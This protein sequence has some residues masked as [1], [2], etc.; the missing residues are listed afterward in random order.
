MRLYYGVW[1]GV[2]YDNRETEE[3]LEPEG[4]DIKNLLQF[5]N[6]NPVMTF[7]S[8]R[9]FLV[10]HPHA[11]LLLAL[12]NYYK[13]V[14]ED[15]CGKCTPCR[16]GSIIISEMLEKAASGEEID[17]D[18]LI[19]VARM[20][21]NTSFCGVGQ[22]CPVALIEAIKTFP[23]DLKKAPNPN[24][25]F[26][27]YEVMTAPCIEACPAHVNVP[28]YIDY[29]K[30]GRTDLATG[31][32]LRHY[33]LVGS[34]GRVCVRL[35]E[36][37][38][39]RQ[40]LEGP[41]DI[42]NLKRFAADSLNYTVEEMFEGAAAQPNEFSPRI[43]V[44][45]AGPAGL[46]CAYHLLLKGYK[47]EVY[48]AQRKAGG[49]ALIGI[50]QYRLPKGILLEEAKV[51]EK[52]G[53]KFHYG[54]RLG[55]DFTID[56]LFSEGFN[57]V[58]IGVG[59]SKG[60]LLGF[61]EDAQN[62]EGYSNGLNFLLKVERGVV[63]GE[64]PTFSG[65]F[66]VVGGG[67]VAMDCSRSAVRM[68]DGK[69]HV[70]YRRTEKQAPAD[71][72]EI[73][74]AKEEGIEFHFLT[75]QKRLV[76]EDGKVVGLECVKLKEGESEPNGRSKLIEIPGT[77]FIIP[78]SNVISAIGQRIDQSIF[79]DKDEIQFDKRGNISVTES[80]ATSRPG[81]FAGGD[82]ATGPTTLIGGMAQGQTAAESI[83]EYLTRGSVGFE[84]R[85]RMTQMIKKCALLT[86]TENCLPSMHRERVQMWE[87]NPAIRRKNFE[88]VELGL[89]AEQAKKE[90]ER[91]MRCY[92]LFSVVTQLPIP[93]SDHWAQK[94]GE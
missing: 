67:N 6:G 75:A 16:S 59:C 18:A 9:G 43:A 5:N 66:V 71:P 88:E 35:C 23:N 39:R 27:H 74:A 49:M 42:K 33:P 86:D 83:H 32:V 79:E 8:H 70:I 55:K 46:T 7:V 11:N 56:D 37:A 73:H 26:G 58:F 61:P 24:N 93:G 82:C 63:E 90:A 89:T 94:Q 64:C 19:D 78:C 92:R 25:A 57:A 81:V 62:I 47:V 51:I 60:M 34:C 20:M 4:L 36:H 65:D 14:E 1:D 44:V 10:F 40:Q 31:V 76:V 15:S 84:P 29:I 50:P 54:H 38:C 21:R 45:G 13:R 72:A 68:T 22:T 2:V 53:G 69:V 12:R 17:W 80:L 30:M 48:E 85:A 52:L 87:L 77:E 91:C 28:R 3:Y 41:V